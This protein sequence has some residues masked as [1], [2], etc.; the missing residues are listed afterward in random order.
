MVSPDVDTARD[1]GVF[2]AMAGETAKKRPP[3]IQNL[4]FIPPCPRGVFRRTAFLSMTR[5]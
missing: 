2:A 1:G 5:D 3:T 4:F